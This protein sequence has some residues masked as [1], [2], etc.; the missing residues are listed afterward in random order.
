MSIFKISFGIKWIF[1]RISNFILR[2][3]QDYTLAF[4][5]CFN[6]FPS[7]RVHDNLVGFKWS[8]ASRALAIRWFNCSS[9]LPP[10]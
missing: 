8:E 2:L 7:R 3:D 6:F 4:F 5:H 9:H 10:T 1:L